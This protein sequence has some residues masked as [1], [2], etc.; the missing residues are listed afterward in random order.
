MN[1]IYQVL[2]LLHQYFQFPGRSLSHTDEKILS[3]R[4]LWYKMLPL[5]HRHDEHRHPDKELFYDILIIIVLPVRCHLCSKNHW[6]NIFW[7]DEVLLPSLLRCSHLSSEARMRHRLILHSLAD[8]ISK[9]LKN[10]DNLHF[11]PLKIDFFSGCS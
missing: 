9:G 1:N 7:H 11:T 5:H 3:S 8:R 2:L 6:L 4:D 10:L